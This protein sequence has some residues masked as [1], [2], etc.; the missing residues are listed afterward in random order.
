MCNARTGN[1]FDFEKRISELVK[2]LETAREDRDISEFLFNEIRNKNTRLEEEEVRIKK[3]IEERDTALIIVRGRI[4]KL[5]RE[6][7]KLENK[8]FNR[9]CTI[10]IFRRVVNLQLDD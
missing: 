8:F 1:Y 10:V 2:N 4:R 5:E 7:R 3:I 9:D 6:T